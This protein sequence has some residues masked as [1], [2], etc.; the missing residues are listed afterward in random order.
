[1]A[2]QQKLT[3]FLWFDDQAEVDAMWDKL[4][5]GGEEG[6]CGWLKDRY[7]LS[8]QVVPTGF[9][10]LLEDKDPVRSQRVMQAMM[11]M[12]KLDMARLERAFRG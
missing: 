8:W 1:M 7:G 12:K 6:A 11:Q 9:V 2:I 5:A 3:P 10:K 4:S